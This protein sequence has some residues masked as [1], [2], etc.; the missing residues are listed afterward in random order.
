MQVELTSRAKKDLK[1]LDKLYREKAS[2]TIDVLAS[3]PFM[4]EKM[5]GE[6]RGQYRIKIPPIR[7]IYLIDQKNKIIT[8][9][10]VGH[11]QGIYK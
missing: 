7:I 9:T 11:R 1:K 5:E 3:N 6:F 4:G 10:A 8:V 2:I